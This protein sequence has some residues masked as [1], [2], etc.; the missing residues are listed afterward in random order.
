MAW[1]AYQ[2]TILA[3][4]LKHL[5][6][7]TPIL[8]SGVINTDIDYRTPAKMGDTIKIP[9]PGQATAHDIVAGPV[10]PARTNPTPRDVTLTIATHKGSEFHVTDVEGVT[11]DIPNMVE[12]QSLAAVDILI[13]GINDSVTN[14]AY[15]Q[16]E[17][18]VNVSSA[19]AATAL[20]TEPMTL[21]ADAKIALDEDNTPVMNR[22]AV[23]GGRYE[24]ALLKSNGVMY[25]DRAGDNMSRN[26]GSVGMLM[27]FDA[28]GNAPS[29][30]T[31]TAGITTTHALKG[32]AT[33]G[34]TS[35][36][37]DTGTATPLAGDYFRF[38]AASGVQK[39]TSVEAGTN[40]WTLG[41]Y[42]GLAANVN[43]DATVNAVLA[44]T[45]RTLAFQRGAI[46]LAV[47]TPIA[48]V[49]GFGVGLSGNRAVMADPQTGIALGLE[50]KRQYKQVSFEYEV[51]YGVAV[52][53]PECICEVV[54][55]AS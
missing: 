4:A 20:G 46:T 13:Q 6:E 36:V 31:H 18:W 54:V 21:L 28:R 39:I 33:S 30:P 24:A 51:M 49:N 55:P 9:V 52:T 17:N 7:N 44:A 48:T 15:Q 14:A 23:L 50:I 32:A 45:E 37:V 26:L 22:Y 8:S 34:A 25:A 42:P 19:P 11:S 27:G 16:A 41:L 47:R 40:D 1:E 3:R 43:N 5:R 53:R 2:T 29:I 38:S 35:V 10:D 12:G